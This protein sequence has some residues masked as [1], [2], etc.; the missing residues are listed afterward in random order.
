M[1]NKNKLLTSILLVCNINSIR[2]P[3]AE[4]ILKVWFNKKIFID[5]CGIRNG[6]IDHM[7]IEVMAENNFDLT[8][9]NSKLFSDLESTYF[10]LIITF[11]NE[12]YN[13]VKSQTKTQDCEIEYIDIPDASQ[14]TGNRQQRLDSYRQVRDLLT[15]KLKDRFSDY[16]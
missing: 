9:H 7:A 12:A 5:S 15:E 2:S 8:N 11:T 14:T 10:D 16:L 1:A 3:M 6:R 4:A 13:E